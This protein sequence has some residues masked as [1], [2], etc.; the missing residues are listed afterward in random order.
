V[1]KRIFGGFVQRYVGNL[2]FALNYRF[3]GLN[4]TGYHLVNIAIH[5]SA[6]LLVYRLVS[7][8]FRT[9]F[10]SGYRS[11]PEAAARIRFVALLAALLFVVH[12]LQTQAVTYIVQRLASLAAMFYL[13]SLTCY[14]RARISQIGPQRSSYTAAAWFAAALLSAGLAMR[15]K[16]ISFTLP[17]VV[18]L[19]ELFFCTGAPR[20]D[21]LKSGS[22][23]KMAIA[24]VLAAAAVAGSVAVFSNR[25][26]GGSLGEI[27][28]SI[29][30][31][32]RLQSSLPRLDYLAT[33]CRVLVTYLRLLIL[34][35]GQ[36]LEYDYP[37]S[38][39]F[40]DLDVLFCLALLLL[41]FAAA[42][43]CLLL[44]RRKAA[45][46]G[47]TAPL[48][49]LCAFGIFWF[50]ITISIESSLIPIVD[51]IFEHRMYLPSAGLFLALS[52][53][54][55]L[56]GGTGKVPGWPRMRVL[57]GVALALV[58]LAGAT[59]ARNALWRDEASFWR[60][61][62]LKS[63]QSSRVFHNLGRALENR[64]D[65]AGA[66]AAYRHA[67]GI[68]GPDRADPLVSLGLIHIKEGRLADA[69]AESQEA[70]AIAA[71]SGAAHNNIGMIYG[72]IGKSDEALGEFYEAARRNPNYAEPYNNI[73]FVYAQQKRYHEALQAYEKCLALDPGY[74]QAYVNRG[75]VFLAT[76]RADQAIVDFRRALQINPSNADAAAQL[77][78]ASQ[79]R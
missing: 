55:S 72:I 71:G 29:D 36:R 10:F 31:A 57:G 47:P 20:A 19:Y 35:V 70:V 21:G 43:Y 8:T 46:P 45:Q 65:L 14:A 6:S 41:L 13:L 39:S 15:T 38:H 54:I 27:I 34:P 51:V 69:L 48:L 68:T 4:V 32:T 37:P 59:L 49:R 50:F 44:S 60:D 17:F 16:E 74:A 1:F 22:A 9:P 79:S 7:L 40:L 42:L 33:Q 24:G 53:L 63:P 61:N 12:P 64:G 66:E 30:K 58:L 76:G 67:A 3:N 62:A 18:V 2:T 11:Q 52:C 75:A 26:S 78:Q 77:R 56:A 73:G 25:F 5:L 23:K 28:N